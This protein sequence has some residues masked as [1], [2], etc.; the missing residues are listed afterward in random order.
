MKYWYRWEYFE[1]PICGA[2]PTY[3]F[4]VYREEDKGHHIITSYDYCDQ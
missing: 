4:R 2:G 1:C 3:K